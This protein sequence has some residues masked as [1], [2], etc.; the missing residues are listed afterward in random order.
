MPHQRR[1]DMCARISGFEFES[2]LAERV[3][4]DP[5][6]IMIIW[7]GKADDLSIEAGF[8]SYEDAGAPA[9]LSSPLHPKSPVADSGPRSRASA[10]VEFVADSKSAG[11]AKS[12]SSKYVGV[13]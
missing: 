3:G 11:R 1:E 12:R 5:L 13:P 2:R 8:D 6:H 9:R 4:E 7:G 10:P